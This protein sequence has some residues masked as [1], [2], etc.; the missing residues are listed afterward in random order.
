MEV[1]KHRDKAVEQKLFSLR[2]RLLNIEGT[3]NYKDPK[4][5]HTRTVNLRQFARKSSSTH[6]F[7]YF[8]VKLINFTKSQNVLETGTC[9]GINTAYMAHSNV[10]N[11]WSIEGVRKFADLAQ[12]RLNQNDLS[13]IKIIRGTVQEKFREVMCK[14]K[15]DL[16]FLDADHR[17]ETIKFYLD[18]IR[19]S[20]YPV[21]CIVIHDIHWSPDMNFAWR[22]AIS[23][24][25]YNLT[26][27]IFQAGIIFPNYPM[28]KQHFTI[29]F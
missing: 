10:K 20:E 15:P 1:I 21:S 28:E 22:E 18:E 11:I 3:A 17:S 13:N 4:T 2:K 23:N 7:S 19:L 26:I 16:I 14:A 12:N 25:D 6:H 9:L 24:R 5:G 27:D 8:L 29:R